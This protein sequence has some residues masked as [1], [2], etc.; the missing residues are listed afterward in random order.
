MKNLHDTL[1]SIQI[2]GGTAT[3]AS[4]NDYVAAGTIIV[5]I[6]QLAI[7]LIALLKKKKQTS[8]EA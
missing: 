5:T 3:I 6:V 4:H 7:K 2:A 8:N 1:S